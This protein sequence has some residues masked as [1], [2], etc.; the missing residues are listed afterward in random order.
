MERSM[1]ARLVRPEFWADSKVARMSD[2]VRLF[3]VG[4]WCVADDCGYIN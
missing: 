3:Y 4:L 1:R 2:S